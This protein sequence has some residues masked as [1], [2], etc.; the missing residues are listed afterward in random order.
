M[1]FYAIARG[2]N[3]GIYTN[4][5]EAQKQIKGFNGAKFRKFDTRQEAQAFIDDNPVL[6]QSSILGIFAQAE[7]PQENDNCL[8]C[9]TDGACSANGTIGARSSFAIV[10]PYHEEYNYAQRVEGDAQT[11]NRGE[12]GA[13]IYAMKQA[14][15]IDQSNTKTLIVYTDSM[16]LIKSLTEWLPSW[17]RNNWNKSDGQQIANLDLVQELD[18]LMQ[19]RKIALRHVRAHTKGTDWES[20]Y[21]DKVDRLARVVLMS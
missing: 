1:V 9:F 7:D 8:I 4:W 6:K 11:N 2:R 16:L 21:N 10:W 14:S 5:P 18:M 20:R 19:H 13:L 12:F 3:P 15:V 17:K